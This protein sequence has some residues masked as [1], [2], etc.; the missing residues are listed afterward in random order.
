M[1]KFKNYRIMQL[2]DIQYAL[3]F[4][5]LIDTYLCG[6]ITFISIDIYA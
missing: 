6:F 3:W 4:D 5:F 2:S 1:G